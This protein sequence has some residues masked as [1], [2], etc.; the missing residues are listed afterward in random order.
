MK[1]VSVV[2]GLVCFGMFVLCIR[3]VYEQS[4]G[5][6]VAWRCNEHGQRNPVAPDSGISLGERRPQDWLELDITMLVDVC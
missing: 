6:V 1:R 4:T 2:L 3:L 5:T